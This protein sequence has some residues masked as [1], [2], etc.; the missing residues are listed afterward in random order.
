LLLEDAMKADMYT[1]AVLTVIA[2]ALV[3]IAAGGPALIP[4][5][6][7]QRDAHVYIA[8]WLDYESGQYIERRLDKKAM[9]VD[10]K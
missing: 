2:V 10:T 9:P 8:G 3:W 7:A 1:K 6:H 4:T 5:A